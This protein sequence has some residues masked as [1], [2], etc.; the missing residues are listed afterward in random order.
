M[1]L[2]N[3]ILLFGYSAESFD[4]LK[5]DLSQRYYVRSPGLLLSMKEDLENGT[6]PL[7]VL[8]CLHGM[9]TADLVI[10]NK[11]LK[12]D[13]SHVPIIMIG[14]QAECSVCISHVTSERRYRLLTP[15]T[16]DDVHNAIETCRDDL[17]PPVA[18]HKILIVDDDR[19]VLSTLRGYLN[20]QYS[21]A[22]AA[23]G[24]DALSYAKT[25]HPDLILMDYSLP[26][27]TGARV[28][29]A[30]HENCTTSTIPFVF[31]TA[32]ADKETV[33]EC[34]RLKPIDYLVKPIERKALLAAVETA[35]TQPSASPSVH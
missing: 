11:L 33:L 28:V 21:V 20:R 25:N 14:S 19:L 12:D 22:V 6:D 7:A 5:A 18:Q 32:S 31:L 15:C 24:A 23:C 1:G 2:N 4:S 29:E 3:T 34:L 17:C 10:L 27:M 35:F 8:V 30:L 16:V 13:L 9:G 26:D